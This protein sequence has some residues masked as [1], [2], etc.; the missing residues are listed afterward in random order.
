VILTSFWMYHPPNQ[1][2]LL[3]LLKL[4]QTRSKWNQKKKGQVNIVM[5]L[6]T[7][8]QQRTRTAA[9]VCEWVCEALPGVKR[10]LTGSSLS[11]VFFLC[12]CV[13]VVCDD[14]RRHA[15]RSSRE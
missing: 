12:V 8:T 3:C 10:R 2:L 11:T 6:I 4:H 9:A 14:C 1:G 13:S 5:A 15:K 7:F